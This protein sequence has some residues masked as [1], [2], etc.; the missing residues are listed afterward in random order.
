[1]KGL[2]AIAFQAWATAHHYWI[3]WPRI[4]VATFTLLA[5]GVS[6]A[7]GWVALWLLERRAGTASRLLRAVGPARLVFSGTLI[8]MLASAGGHLYSPDESTIYAMAVGI[9]AHGRP[10]A[11]ENEPYQLNQLVGVVGPNARPREDESWAYP[12]YGIVPVLLLT[13]L[14]VVGHL[15]GPSPELPP[16]AFPFG[17]RAVPLVPLLLGPLVASASA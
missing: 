14:Y 13:P 11:Y 17:N 4:R 15:V 7:A 5:V 10:A 1:M 3:F 9:V 2:A 16:A 6:L 8:V 12:K